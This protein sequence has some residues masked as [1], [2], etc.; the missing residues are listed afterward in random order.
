MIFVLSISYSVSRTTF[1]TFIRK[2][3]T[4]IPVRVIFSGKKG[5]QECGPF[6]PDKITLMGITVL[7]FL[8]KVTNLVRAPGK[9]MEGMDII[10]GLW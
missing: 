8:M 10:G 2:S 1:V 3:H 5:P 9:E 7:L 4:V 6:L